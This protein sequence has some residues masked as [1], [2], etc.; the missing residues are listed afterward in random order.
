MARGTGVAGRGQAEAF[1]ETAKLIEQLMTAKGLPIPPP[2]APAPAR[3]A[4]Q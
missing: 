4:V 2:P 1:P 3:S